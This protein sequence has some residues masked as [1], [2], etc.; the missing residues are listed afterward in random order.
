MPPAAFAGWPGFWYNGAMKT[1]SIERNVFLLLL[2]AGIALMVAV[3][4]AAKERA[5]DFRK[6]LEVVHEEGR[7]DRALVPAADEFEIAEIT[8]T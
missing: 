3:P 7:R 4:S 1:T 8:E 5:Y 6:R 2:C